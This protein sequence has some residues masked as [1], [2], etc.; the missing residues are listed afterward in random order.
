MANVRVSD[1]GILSLS[2]RLDILAEFDSV[3]VKRSYIISYGSFSPGTST[4]RGPKTQ[5]SSL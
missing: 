4:C 1:L 2:L 3:E 5:S